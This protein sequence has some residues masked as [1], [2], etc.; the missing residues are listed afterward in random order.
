MNFGNALVLAVIG[1]VA[2]FAGYWVATRFFSS[3]ARIER[4]RRRSNAP[5]SSK[6][7]GPMVKFS[8]RTP[9]QDKD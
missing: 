2:V 9:K 8:V 5:V 4:R 7:K 6:R 1:L 3:E